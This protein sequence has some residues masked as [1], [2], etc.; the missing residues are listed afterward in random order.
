MPA[1][2]KF[3]VLLLWVKVP[4]ALVQFP[5]TMRSFALALRVDPALRVRLPAVSGWAS[6]QLAPLFMR[7]WPFKLMA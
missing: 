6:V 3:T 5:L 1:P 4:P 7:T 2:L